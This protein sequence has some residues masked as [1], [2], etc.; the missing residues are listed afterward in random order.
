[1]T[2]HD[3]YIQMQYASSPRSVLRII[4]VAIA[5]LAVFSV[6]AIAAPPLPKLEGMT[7][8]GC[9]IDRVSAGHFRT[10][11]WAEHAS[12]HD[13]EVLLSERST[14]KK[15]M[16]DCDIWMLALEKRI[17]IERR[18]TPPPGLSLALGPAELRKL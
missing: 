16:A 10:Y 7:S 15:A 9:H 6:P 17:D 2:C 5:A 3:T 18:R 4:I 13:F 11:A 14:R 1:M 12:L 8:Y